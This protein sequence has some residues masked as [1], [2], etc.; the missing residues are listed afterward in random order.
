MC[1]SQCQSQVGDIDGYTGG[2]TEKAVAGGRVGP[3][4]ACFIGKQFK[5]LMNGD[6]WVIFWITVHKVMF[7]YFFS[8]NHGGTNKLRGLG[9]SSTRISVSK[10]TLG[11][12]ICRNT[13]LNNL[14][15]TRNHVMKLTGEEKACSGRPELDWDGIVED[16]KKGNK[17]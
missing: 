13:N 7:R 15:S 4:F 2:L 3:T 8:H 5:V 17:Q 14:K 16:I 10:R 6:R 12:I 1:F 9:T 11:D